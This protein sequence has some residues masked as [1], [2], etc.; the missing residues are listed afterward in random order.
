MLGLIAAALWLRGGG[1]EPQASAQ[2]RRVSTGKEGGIPDSGRQRMDM[3]AELQ[4]INGR[5]EAIDS[6]L[7]G[8][9]YRIQTLE[10]KGDA[11]ADQ[12]AR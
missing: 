5:L 2:V 6:A 3:I 12:G 8:G 10:A 1:L 4:K 9:T 11:K 7:R